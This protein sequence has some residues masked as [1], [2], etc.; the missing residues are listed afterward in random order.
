M[1][2]QQIICHTTKDAQDKI[3]ELVEQA[4][5]LSITLQDAEDEPVLEPLPG[6][7]PLWENIIMTILFEADQNLQTLI[8]QLDEHKQEWH[9]SHLALEI[10]EDQIWERAWMKNF[11]PM[12]FGDNLWIYPG[13]YDIPDDDRVKILLDPG[14]AFGTGTHPTT[15][16]CLEWLDQNPPRDL[17][18]VD[19]GCGSGIL[20]IAAAKLGAKHITA[21][22]IDPQAITATRDNM[23]RNTIASD[24]I[25]TYLV[26]DMPSDQVDLLVANILSGPLIELYPRLDSLIKK[27]GSL[28]L[29]GI[30]IEQKESIIS[31]YS[32]TFDD[33]EVKV[34]GDWIR[35]TGVKTGTEKHNPF[36]KHPG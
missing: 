7:T 31:T 8:T 4:G 27:K 14:L 30:L 36:M 19:Y 28:V 9:I 5:S 26:D 15:A 33:L 22:D 29:S 17:S 35:V 12:Q 2:W 16:L 13:G 11:R 23:Q 1:P 20:A 18:V 6:E 3:S 34:L 32:Q 25:S 10:L 21:T 24:K